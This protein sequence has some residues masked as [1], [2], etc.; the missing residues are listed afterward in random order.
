MLDRAAQYKVVKVSI[1]KFP[2]LQDN[3]FYYHASITDPHPIVLY[4]ELGGPRVI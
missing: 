3:Q 1:G 2:T 4:M